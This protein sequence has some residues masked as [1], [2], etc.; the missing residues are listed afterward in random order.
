MW[1]LSAG[2]ACSLR[3]GQPMIWFRSTHPMGSGLTIWDS[4]LQEHSG[5][6]VLDRARVGDVSTV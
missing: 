5:F 3:S 4:R 2:G 1:F 6:V